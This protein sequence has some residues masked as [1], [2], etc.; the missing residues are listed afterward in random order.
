MFI[1]FNF[2][3]GWRREAKQF[4]KSTF[5][6]NC[7]RRGRDGEKM[8]RENFGWNNKKLEKDEIYQMIDGTEKGT[9]FFRFKISPD[10]TKENPKKDLDLK[11]LTQKIMQT[12]V[13]RK[14][15]HVQFIAVCHDDHT[16]IA[17]V[18]AIVFFRGRIDKVDI[19]ALK[20]AALQ[21]T[22]E[23]RHDRDYVWKKIQK[24]IRLLTQPISIA[25]PAPVSRAKPVK[26]VQAR[27]TP[28]G[29]RRLD[30]G[31]WQELFATQAH[32][33]RKTV[34]LELEQNEELTL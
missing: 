11:H 10:P 3:K 32:Q 22:A 5:R 9:V 31:H 18:H 4:I 6:Y 20:K 15:K 21:E 7:H 13:D 2:V 33:C 8:S 27:P 30:C 34:Q 23:Q 29:F 16:D 1:G 28:L 17:H 14:Q 12:L 25:K 24:R 19:A 26:D